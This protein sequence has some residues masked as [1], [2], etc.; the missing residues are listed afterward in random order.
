MPGVGRLFVDGRQVGEGRISKIAY[1]S[2]DTLDVGADLGTPV[3]RDYAVPFSFT[4][5]LDKVEVELL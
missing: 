1:G 2:Y 3:S 5:R 4:G